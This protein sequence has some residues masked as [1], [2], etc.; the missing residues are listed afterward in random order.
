MNPGQKKG[1]KV[2]TPLPEHKGIVGLASAAVTASTAIVA[3][4]ASVATAAAAAQNEDQ[5]D[6]P[7]AVAAKT[8]ISTTHDT[9]TSSL[10]SGRA[11]TRELPA[12]ELWGRRLSPF[13]SYPM[14]RGANWFPADGP[15]MKG[16]A[17][18]AWA[19]DGS[20]RTGKCCPAGRTPDAYD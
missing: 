15:V 16:I 19:R 4:K 20:V 7:A 3:E 8:A 2:E 17:L 1:R 11:S 12:G 5:T 9:V 13:P 14:Y 18:W 10:N 6:D